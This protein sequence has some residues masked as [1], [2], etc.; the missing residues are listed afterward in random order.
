MFISYD[1]SVIYPSFN[2]LSKVWAILFGLLL[3]TEEGRREAFFL[4][5]L[6]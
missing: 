4:S 5:L 3:A 6:E 1:P 2:K